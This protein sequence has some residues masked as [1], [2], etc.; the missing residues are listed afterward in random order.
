MQFL[1]PG[2]LWAIGLIS[3]PIIIHLF[4]FRRVKKVYFSNTSFLHQVKRET[5]KRSQLK[6][7]LVLAARILF[8]IFLVLAFAQPV[9]RSPDTTL[10]SLRKIYLD[11]SLSMSRQGLGGLSLLD[12][13][14]QIVEGLIASSESGLNYS[15][16]T[17]DFRSDPARLLV[18]KE[19]VERLTEVEY[20][21]SF[22]TLEDV[23][24]RWGSD[25]MSPTAEYFLISD[26]QEPM[27]GDFSALEKDSLSSIYLIKLSNELDGNIFVDSVYLDAVL[28]LSNDNKL[29]VAIRNI[30][31]E[32]RND[33][34]VKVFTDSIQFSTFTLDIPAQ[35]VK[36]TSVNI[37]AFDQISGNYY[38]EIEDFSQS[39]DN[40]YYFTI[41][42][43]K[44]IEVSLLYENQINKYLK[45]AFSNK[46]IFNLNTYALSNIN[47]QEIQASDLIILDGLD[48]IPDWMDASAVDGKSVLLIP[49]NQPSFPSYQQLL[50]FSV[51]G[52]SDTAVYT[53]SA[54]SLNSPWFSGI[55]SNL[56]EQISLPAVNNPLEVQGFYNV[57]LNTNAGKPFLVKSGG[58]N[59][60][61]FTT[62]LADA[63]TDFHKH[64]LF[65]PVLYKL[66]QSSANR[67]QNLAYSFDEKVV[68]IDAGLVREAA[69]PKISNNE[70]SFI[71]GVIRTADQVL[72]DIP[73]EITEPGFY[74]LTI[75]NDT[76]TQLAFNYNK[77]ESNINSL[78]TSD[79]KSVISGIGNVQIFD[80]DNAEEF[81][82]HFSEVN[83]GVG[84]WKYALLLALIFLLIEM[85]LLRFS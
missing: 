26:F 47:Y 46:E 69:L 50:Q 29:N 2:V 79:L 5:K 74:T 48:K 36:N 52:A 81:K 21:R 49:G 67:T 17:N 7:L 83:E 59:F 35:S 31:E 39:F 85:L 22:R 43:P 84:L 3:V 76:V 28:G 63:S 58:A 16:T 72:L 10:K 51:A 64:A 23:M 55:F 20:S 9:T 82:R 18:G 78:S 65:I 53:V 44:K 19:L 77:A 1:Y 13:G 30:G 27:T 15:L 56:T 8:I 37:G 66:A 57:L 12:E 73:E 11:N 25:V 33:V 80:V 71:P 14:V 38:I 75:D 68:A 41:S 60:F 42:E 61:L 6:K 45:A 34:L 4:N 54:K 70:R 40:K 32:N 24:N 62:P